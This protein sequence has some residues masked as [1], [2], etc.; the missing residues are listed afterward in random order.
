MVQQARAEDL[1]DD[2]TPLVFCAPI[3]KECG[4]VLYEGGLTIPLL[5][6]TFHLGCE[7]AK[8]ALQRITLEDV[9]AEERITEKGEFRIGL[10]Q[11]MSHDAKVRDAGRCIGWFESGHLGG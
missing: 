11:S 1:N 2:E 4:N 6:T 7:R 3:L 9:S 5:R 10:F 8:Q